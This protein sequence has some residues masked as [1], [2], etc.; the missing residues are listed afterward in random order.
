MQDVDSDS[1]SCGCE[2]VALEDVL[3]LRDGSEGVLALRDVPT[4]CQDSVP[5]VQDTVVSATQ[6]V[7]SDE[8]LAAESEVAH[9]TVGEVAWTAHVDLEAES[10]LTDLYVLDW[11]QLSAGTAVDEVESSEDEGYVFAAALDDDIELIP[12]ESYSIGDD[13][14]DDKVMSYGAYRGMRY[15]ELLGQ[16]PKYH[17][18]LKQAYKGKSIP[19]YVAA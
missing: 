2:A 3:A 9:S 18:E 13:E 12:C 4:A 15:K 17:E 16:F 10:E 8:L 11:N 7:P 14:D 19:N 1:S 5:V 6:N